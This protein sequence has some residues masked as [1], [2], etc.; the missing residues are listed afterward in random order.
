MT[1]LQ[2]LT[3]CTGESRNTLAL[4]GPKQQRTIWESRTKTATPIN[5]TSRPLFPGQATFP[6]STNI[7]SMGKQVTTNRKS[8]AAKLKRR[9]A[10]E[11][12]SAA[13][14][15]DGTNQLSYPTQQSRPQH[16][17]SH[18]PPEK[19]VSVS[20]SAQNGQRSDHVMYG[21]EPQPA[22][23]GTDTEEDE[24][25]SE[26]TLA[27]NDLDPSLAAA[28]MA[29]AREFRSMTTEFRT[30]SELMRKLLKAVKEN[31]AEQMSMRAAALLY[32]DAV[33]L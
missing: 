1:V 14:G 15:Y 27:D 23:D 9:R 11:E 25:G 10:T 19:N 6:Y 28:V 2:P 26:A 4:C 33:Q 32:K 21:S 13:P 12:P 18:K 7:S 20:G 17:N 29:M 5:T 8:G 30:M 3:S 16:P 24:T 22:T 31:N